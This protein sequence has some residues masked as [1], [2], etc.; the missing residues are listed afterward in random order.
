LL[1]KA[2]RERT[3]GDTGKK[4]KKTATESQTKDSPINQGGTLRGY[5]K[6]GGAA[7]RRKRW[8]VCKSR[9]DMQKRGNPKEAP[10]RTRKW[11][12]KNRAGSLTGAQKEKEETTKTYYWIE[13]PRQLKRGG[14]LT[15]TL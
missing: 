12:K 11:P 1:K 10:G 9:G 7:E 13:F 5:R 4:T 6:K 3:S 14:R 8:K 15:A 2:R